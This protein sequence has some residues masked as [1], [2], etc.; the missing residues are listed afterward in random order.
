MSP[1]PKISRRTLTLGG[2]AAGAVALATGAV[3]EA[4]KLFKR[5][6]R[7]T[8]AELVNRLDDPDKAAA[9]GYRLL[10]GRTLDPGSTLDKS[11]RE[12]AAK[13]RAGLKA[14]S[15]QRLVIADAVDGRLAEA[16]GWVIPAVMGDLCIMATD[17][18]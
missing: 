2:I 6:A 16:G 3:Y 12:S 18:R 1:P 11:I 7:G 4:P 5:R 17:G 8:Y 15:L 14:G 13:I 9:I 10:D